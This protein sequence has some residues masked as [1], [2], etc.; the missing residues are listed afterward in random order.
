M[1]KA[2]NMFFITSLFLQAISLEA[3]TFPKERPDWQPLPAEFREYLLKSRKQEYRYNVNSH[4]IREFEVLD[5]R[6]SNPNYLRINHTAIRFKKDM[7]DELKNCWYVFVSG[8]DCRTAVSLPAADHYTAEGS[9]DLL[10]YIRDVSF[11]NGLRVARDVLV[12]YLA[13]LDASKGLIRGRLIETTEN[14]QLVY[15]DSFATIEESQRSE[16]G[17]YLV[18]GIGGEKS[19]NAALIQRAAQEI[20]SQGFQAEMLQVDANLGSDHNALML[21]DMLQQRL[22]KLKKV[23][24]V[25]ASKGV[26]DFITYFLEHGESLS[27]QEREKIK[28]MVSLSGVIR[29]SIVADYI[30]DSGKAMPFFLRGLLKLIGREDTI[31]G[32]DSLSKNPWKYHDV[33][34]VHKFFPK[35]KWLSMP[36]IPEGADGLTNLSLWEGFLKKPTYRWKNKASPMDGLVESAASILPPDT[37]ITEYIIP[38]YGPHAMALGS[39]TPSLRVAPYSMGDIKDKVKPEAGAEMLSAMFRALPQSLIE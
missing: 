24:L 9:L 37:G 38:I 14:P 30:V 15:P 16:I 12:E 32:I 21:R 4:Y 8:G 7:P 19:A 18:L 3:K 1:I 20:R 10:K 28:L 29:R 25:A 2:L 26:A 31:K 13:Q 35:M 6:T 33:K 17:V 39:Y 11:T 22:P 36:A 23:I 27:I 34:N 5:D